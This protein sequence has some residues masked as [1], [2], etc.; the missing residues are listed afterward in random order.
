M[1]NKVLVRIFGIPIKGCKPGKSWEDAAR[2]TRE[3]L[4][5]KFGESV[6]VEYIEFLPSR[7]KQFPEVVDLIRAGEAQIPIVMV[8][9]VMISSGGKIDVGRIERY[10]LGMG[11]KKL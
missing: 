11:L 5:S 9:D 6:D 8:N 10:L 3:I 7:W 2:I 1:G 4:T